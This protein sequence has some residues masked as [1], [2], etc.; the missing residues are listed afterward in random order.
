LK[1]ISLRVFSTSP[2]SFLVIYHH[3]KVEEGRAHANKNAGMVWYGGVHCQM[4]SNK[5][6][7]S[8]WSSK[9]NLKHSG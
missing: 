7:K 1:I 6:I 5:L 2:G 9:K 8:S 4:L 3:P